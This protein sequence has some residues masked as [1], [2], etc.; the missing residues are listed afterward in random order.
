M[1]T[2]SDLFMFLRGGSFS[3][4]VKIFNSEKRGS[5]WPQLRPFSDSAPQNYPEKNIR[6]QMAR[7]ALFC[8]PVL[9]LGIHEFV[10]ISHMPDIWSKDVKF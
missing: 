3:K 5:V 2:K 1:G 9:L 8:S 10:F 7:E 6:I 4:K